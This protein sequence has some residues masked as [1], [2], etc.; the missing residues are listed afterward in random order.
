LAPLVVGEIIL[1]ALIVRNSVFLIMRNEKLEVIQK[2][3]KKIPN[4]I[5]I[6]NLKCFLI[7]YVLKNQQG[8][9][10]YWFGRD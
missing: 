6:I 1:I 5:C 7:L 9:G 8:L 2:K 3:E 4:I 10:K